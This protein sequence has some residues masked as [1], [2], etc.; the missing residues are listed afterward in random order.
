MKLTN[1]HSRRKFLSWTLAAAGGSL[2]VNRLW[3]DPQPPLPAKLVG[4]KIKN[5][6]FGFIEACARDDGGYTPSPDLG[7]KGYADTAGSDLAAI[8]YAAVL[9]K[10]FGWELPHRERSAEFIQRHQQPDGVFINLQGTMNPKEDLAILYNAVQGVVSLRALGEK[11]KV[12]PFQV[13]ER[14]FEKD[15]FKKLPMYTLSFYPLFYAALGKPFPAEYRAAVARYIE[16]DQAADGYLGDHVASTFHMIHFFR[17]VGGHTPH[18]SAVVA[19]VLRDQ[20]P[21]GG[22]H[23][24]TQDWDV[25]AC[26][27]AVFILR[28]L[29]WNSPA[30]RAAIGRATDWA[31]ASRNSDGGF[32]HYPGG[33]SD[34]DA[35]YFQLGTLIQAEQ[36]PGAD[37]DLPDAETLGWGHAMIPEKVYLRT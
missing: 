35:V 34:M 25:H 22:W 10:T 20:R 37:F 31:L 4:L 5:E 6:T 33:H 36:I 19:R 16:Q 17:L 27:D 30:S 15:V 24:K 1:G 21:D 32:S 14:F 18:A 2:A 8:T 9:A 7:Y 23:L 26:F 3:S 12:D 13:L 11:P 29:S 28:Q